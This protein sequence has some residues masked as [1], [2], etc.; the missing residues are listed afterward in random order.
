MTLTVNSACDNQSHHVQLPRHGF[1]RRR[2]HRSY[3]QKHDL[4]ERK[5]LG[6]AL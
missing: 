5:V 1:Q 6:G 2:L 3:G 4:V